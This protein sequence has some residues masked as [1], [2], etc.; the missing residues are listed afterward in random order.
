ML[1]FYEA[2]A[3]YT[4]DDG[5]RG[6]ADRGCRGGGALRHA[7]HRSRD[8]RAGVHD[9]RF[10]A[11]SGCRRCSAGLARDVLALTTRS[12]VQAAMRIGVE[13]VATLS[14][15]EAA[16]RDV[17][18]ARGVEDRRR[19]RSW[20]T[21]RWSSRRWRSRS[22]AIRRLTERFELLRRRK[23][24]GER[25]LRAE[26]PD[27]PARS[28][29]RRRR[30]CK[31]AGDEEATRRGRGLPA[32]DGVRHAA[33]GRRGHRHRPAVHVPHRTPQHIRDVIL[34]PTMRPE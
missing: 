5:S 7:G 29:S 11:S 12:C 13:K 24:D 17:P 14:R 21:I 34:F 18:G 22:A 26:R 20:S 16:G 4:R 3:D 6:A 32:R 23:R 27:R 1:E 25:V 30:G 19:R 8:M 2:Y 15:P 28:A 31:A 33:H 10:R 9:R